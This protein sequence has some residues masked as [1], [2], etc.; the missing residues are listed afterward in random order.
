MLAHKSDETLGLGKDI[1]FIPFDDITELLHVCLP[2]T[3]ATNLTRQLYFT[4][5]CLYVASIALTKISMLLLYLRL[6]PGDQ[7]RLAVKMVLAFTTAWGI[8]ILFANVFACSPI[9]YFWTQWDGEH[10]G[11]C[12]NNDQL[13]WAHALINIVLDAVI[14]AL[15]MPTLFKLNMNWRKKA[16]V[17]VMFA[18]GI[19]Y[20]SFPSSQ[21][22]TDTDMPG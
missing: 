10:K 11:E 22:F 13:L 14:I 4:V 8:A 21:P 15:P 6:F 5:E 7:L 17:I 12:V 19:V 16:G 18:I 2:P 1:W 3:L 9:S 20:V